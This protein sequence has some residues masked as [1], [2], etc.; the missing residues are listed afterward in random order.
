MSRDRQAP[1]APAVERQL[2]GDMARRGLLA[3]PIVAVVTGVGWGVDG[4]LSAM[5]AVALVLANFAVS[6]LL[7][8]WAA[9]ISYAAIAA[10]AM[11]GFV[12]RGALV[13][14]AVLAVKDQGWV[15]RFPLGLTLV[16]AHL[17]L[18]V[19]EARHVSASL[20]FPGLKPAVAR[21]TEPAIRAEP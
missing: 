19:W 20:A 4:I 8:G 7:L 5:F 9:R 13:V 17:G 2:A 3:T 14:L 18:L 1:P 15:E 6:A 10:T 21:P 11:F 16:T 12:V